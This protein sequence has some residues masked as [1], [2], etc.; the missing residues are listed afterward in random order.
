MAT[1]GQ[2]TARLWC[3]RSPIADDWACLEVLEAVGLPILLLTRGAAILVGWTSGQPRQVGPQL[4]WQRPKAVRAAGGS[5]Q[6]GPTAARLVPQDD[7]GSVQVFGW[8]PGRWPPVLPEP[9]GGPWLQEGIP[10]IP[11]GRDSWLLVPAWGL[12]L[13]QAAQDSRAHH[14]GHSWL[15]CLLPTFL[16]PSWANSVFGR[17]CVVVKESLLLCSCLMRVL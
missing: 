15:S 1:I 13:E 12:I 7:L 10:H 5:C 16:K 9:V 2:A 6:T 17:D 4:V 3:H 14:L 8:Y 11:Y